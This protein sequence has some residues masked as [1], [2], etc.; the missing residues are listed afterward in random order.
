LDKVEEVGRKVDIPDCKDCNDDAA[1][2][3]DTDVA[4]DA[5][6]DIEAKSFFKDDGFE[7]DGKNLRSLTGSADRHAA[8]T[9]SSSST[10]LLL[11]DVKFH[12]IITT[13]CNT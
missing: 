1:A 6:A 3:V 13:I 9:S 8:N 7:G 2:D 10:I 4:A 5:D 12:L 11:I